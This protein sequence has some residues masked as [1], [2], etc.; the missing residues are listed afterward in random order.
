MMGVDDHWVSTKLMMKGRHGGPAES[1]HAGTLTCI[2]CKGMHAC[3]HY[4]YRSEKIMQTPIYTYLIHDNIY[5]SSLYIYIYII[6]IYIYIYIYR[7]A[8]IVSAL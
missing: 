6:F 7:V 4:T 5:I 1:L 3:N 2:P 8:A